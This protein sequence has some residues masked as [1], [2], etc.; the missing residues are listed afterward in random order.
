MRK[1]RWCTVV[2]AVLLLAA[3]A[4]APAAAD[5]QRRPKGE[6][7]SSKAQV[8]TAQPAPSSPPPRVAVPRSSAERGERRPRGEA[9]R[10]PGGG[11]GSASRGHGHFPV[12]RGPYAWHPWGWWGWWGWWGGPWYHPGYYPPPGAYWYARQA[13][14]TMGALDTDIR[15]EK[16]Q[17]WLN[18]NLIG[19][20]DNFDG[21]P[22]Y[23]WLEEGTYDLVFYHPGYE[24]IARQYT[25]Y[26]GVV[27]DVEDRMERGESVRPED[28][29]SA[30]TRR[31]DERLRR[32]AER[33]EAPGDADRTD[34]RDRVLAEREALE[35][36][37][38]LDARVEPARV[39]LEIG[40]P[41]AAVYLDGRFVGTADELADARAGLIVDP[42]EHEIEVVRPGYVSETAT[43]T[44]E[45]GEAVELTVELEEAV[46]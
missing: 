32:R 7:G 9:E 11:S 16:A 37:P 10:R 26:P 27:I 2:G 5:G 17:V 20:A 44:A 19:V 12:F 36:E 18:G 33:G 1:R 31:R 29:V 38:Y 43:F 23:L 46:R 22:R 25:I 6:S 42:G 41:D 15:P 28:L 39:R 24:T 21:W 13:S 35:E 14:P 4:A 8:R 45:A 34:W 30:E 3:A 40:P